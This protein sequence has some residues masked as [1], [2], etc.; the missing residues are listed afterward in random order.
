MNAE[1]F[2]ECHWLV[3]CN[4][5]CW[6]GNLGRH[7]LE[8][9]RQVI[10]SNVHPVKERKS[11]IPFEFHLTMSIIKRLGDRKLKKNRKV[12]DDS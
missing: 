4:C 10:M 1:D 5:L 2:T 9:F 11:F 6:G 12:G 8:A 7:L 3:C